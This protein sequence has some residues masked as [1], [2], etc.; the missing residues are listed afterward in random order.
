MCLPL[1]MFHN[2]AY[3]RWAISLQTM[4]LA[5]LLD[6]SILYAA[7]VT[8]TWQS[9]TESDLAGYLVYQRTLPSIDFGTPIF[10]GLSPTPSSPSTNISNL[11]LG[12]TYGFIVTAYDTSGNESQPSQEKQITVSSNTTPPPP[13]TISSPAPP[14][15]IFPP[16]GSIL[17][18]TRITF[19]GAHIDHDEN[20]ILHIGTTEGGTQI[21]RGKMKPDHSRTVSGLPIK[22]TIYVTFLTKNSSGWLKQTHNY[23]M[24]VSDSQKTTKS[25]KNRANSKGNRRR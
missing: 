13:T 22:G 14:S 3:H 19:R 4:F 7:D 18:T 16:P 8:I 12:T 2:Y 23:S 20:H 6:G 5:I 1:L 10:S 11:Q 25:N 17:T 21:Y 15:L 24:N 9:N